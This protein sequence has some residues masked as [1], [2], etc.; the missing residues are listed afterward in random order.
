VKPIRERGGYSA[1]GRTVSE[2][3][4]PPPSVTID[5]FPHCDQRVLHA[6]GQG[7]RGSWPLLERV[8]RRIIQPLIHAR[9]RRHGFRYD[10]GMWVRR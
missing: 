1:G 2:L 10:K 8:R 6:P 4:P 3:P 7:G 5:K 9:M